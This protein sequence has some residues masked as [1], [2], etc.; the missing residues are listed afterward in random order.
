M[1]RFSPEVQEAIDR[2]HPCSQGVHVCGI[3]EVK[4]VFFTQAN[5]AGVTRETF[6]RAKAE[7]S[8]RDG[9]PHDFIVDFCCG[10]F[11]VDDDFPINR[12][13]LPRLEAICNGNI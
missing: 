10:D 2:Y 3:D 5:F 9:D 7:C 4:E 1:T 13:M 6:E 12:Q 8:T 11:T